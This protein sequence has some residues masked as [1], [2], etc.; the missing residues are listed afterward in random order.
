MAGPSSPW[1]ANDRAAVMIGEAAISCRGEPIASRCLRRTGRCVFRG[2]EGERSTPRQ[3]HRETHGVWPRWVG[4]LNDETGVRPARGHRRPGPGG[5]RRR[6]GG[7]ALRRRRST[8][9]VKRGRQWD[10][11]DRRRIVCAPSMVKGTDPVAVEC[12]NPDYLRLPRVS[13]LGA[14][15]RLHGA[16]TLSRIESDVRPNLTCRGEGNCWME[17][18]EWSASLGGSPA[19]HGL[20]PPCA[21]GWGSLPIGCRP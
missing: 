16:R 9:L 2:I 12:I 14:R 11:E 3:P 20:G 13:R 10:G 4:W 19:S 18:R 1:A 17:D 5:G 15:A 21:P 8:G 7:A 6:C